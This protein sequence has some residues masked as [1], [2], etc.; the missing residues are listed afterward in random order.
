M[1]RPG[2]VSAMLGGC[3]DRR[4]HHSTKGR[5][6]LRR[7]GMLPV[8]VESCGM[9]QNTVMG[10]R[11]CLQTTSHEFGRRCQARPHVGSSWAIGLMPVW[12]SGPP[13]R[14]CKIR[15]RSQTGVT[16]ARHGVDL[17]S[18][19]RR[20]LSFIQ[21]PAVNTS[22]I[23]RRVSIRCKAKNRPSP[24]PA[25]AIGG[26]SEVRICANGRS[27]RDPPHDSRARSSCSTDQDPDGKPK[28]RAKR[29]QGFGALRPVVA[30]HQAAVGPLRTRRFT[31]CLRVNYPPVGAARTDA[32]GVEAAASRITTRIHGGRSFS[33]G[34]VA[35]ACF[36]IRCRIALLVRWV[37]AG[38]VRRTR[39]EW[40]VLN[41][42]SKTS[43]S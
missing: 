2:V 15:S 38:P 34:L 23:N 17:I 21:A 30:W 7:T 42:I 1:G 27:S 31:R 11:R 8:R 39:S 19:L 36:A 22:V 24:R 41:H 13:P 37:S 33:T 40:R 14:F 35:K 18:N 3:S 9:R 5:S 6:V 43:V 16:T 32:T 12:R 10:Y 4:S 28:A 20:S 25:G 29:R 26:M